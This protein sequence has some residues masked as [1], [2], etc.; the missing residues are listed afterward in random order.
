MV[1]EW[2]WQ[3]GNILIDCVDGFIILFFTRSML[4]GHRI[5]Q[6]YLYYLLILPFAAAIYLANNFM[7]GGVGA[8]LCTVLFFCTVL[9]VN[10]D[11]WYIKAA[12]TLA[13]LC[14]QTVSDVF[15][16]GLLSVLFPGI[17]LLYFFYRSYS[18]NFF[19]VAITSRLLILTIVLTF[20]RRTAAPRISGKD[21]LLFLVTPLLSIAGGLTM[22]EQNIFTGASYS[23]LLIA[24]MLVVVNVAAYLQLV[25]VSNS[26]YALARRE[27][28]A[29]AMEDKSEQ[30]LRLVRKNDALNG[31]KHD[32]RNHLLSIAEMLRQGNAE[33]AE[34]Y[35]QEVS[36]KIM[37]NTF[38]IKSGNIML[39]A[40]L[41]AKISE[42]YSAG[43]PIDLQV[44][45]P[46]EFIDDVDICTII[47]N[48]FD[49]AIYANNAMPPEQ[50]SLEF[51]ITDI[52]YF[53]RIMMRNPF[54]AAPER[55]QRKG[56]GLGLVQIEE[57][58]ARCGGTFQY[59][60]DGEYWVAD[61]LLPVP[62]DME[63][64][65]MYSLQTPQPAM[66]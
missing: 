58:A 49:N 56:Q 25:R 55:K 2:V 34:R 10:T 37:E 12:W 61:V 57:A 33:A 41:S 18:V 29:Q 64:L 52:G 62:K 28:A 46:K 36:D 38:L 15:I 53:C 32:I 54:T 63:W 51:R 7:P 5:K 16:T 42:V 24:L 43:I 45:V 48:L 23:S 17:D 40:I 65:K 47:G 31:W 22:M 27:A 13:V 35:L 60:T 11:A 3:A 21:W 1:S 66:Q 26:S 19:V 59:R 44:S 9:A 4:H 50:R 14:I 6:W 30:Y 39:D 20:T 8:A